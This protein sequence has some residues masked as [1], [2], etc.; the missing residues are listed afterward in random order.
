MA[1]HTAVQRV[2][3]RSTGK[4]TAYRYGNTGADKPALAT[5]TVDISFRGAVI[6]TEFSSPS[7]GMRDDSCVTV[8][9]L[10][11]HFLLT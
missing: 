5:A 6:V 10:S 9:P 2:T 7:S 11:Q 1:V 3:C 4:R 8:A